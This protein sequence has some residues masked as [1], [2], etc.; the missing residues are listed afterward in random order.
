MWRRGSV[1]GF[2]GKRKMVTDLPVTLMPQGFTPANKNIYEIR[3]GE[4]RRK[5]AGGKLNSFTFL[6]LQGAALVQLKK[7][8]KRKKRLPVEVNFMRAKLPPC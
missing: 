3:E 6:Y 7:P 2:R 1:C 4:N 8:W 5:S